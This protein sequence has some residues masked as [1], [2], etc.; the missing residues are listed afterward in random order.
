M[1]LYGNPAIRQGLSPDG[2]HWAFTTTHGS[3]WAPMTWISYLADYQLYGLKPQGYHLTNVLLHSATTIL[4]F[5]V[6]WRMTGQLWPCAFVAAVFA[7]HPLH[8]ESVAWLSERKGLLSGLFFV[9][10]LG[11]YVQYVRRRSLPVRCLAY[12]AMLVFF[13]LGLMSKPM[14]VT[15]PFVLLLLDY[16]PLGRMSTPW[17]GHSCLPGR[18]R[19]LADKNGCPTRDRVASACR[20]D[21]LAAAGGRLLRDRP[22]GKAKPSSRWR[23]SRCRRG[24]AT[25]WS[26]MLITWARRFGPRIWPSSIRIRSTPCRRGNRSS[27]LLVSAGRHG[28][29]AGPLAAQSLSA[30]RLALVRG[31][32]RAGDRAGADW[33]ACDGRPLH[34][35]AADRLCLALT[36]AALDAVRSWP[37]RAW[38]CGALA[39]LAIVAL[40]ACAV[41]ADDLL[42]RQRNSL[43]P[44]DRLHSAEQPGPL[45]SRRRI[46]Q[47]EAVL[48]GDR[49]V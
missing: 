40:M 46:V 48:R 31:N 3:Q 34:V 23:K 13:A 18:S 26:P 24:S 5:L 25:P 7:V 33:L 42:A 32:A 10:T 9:L 44:R 30:G 4:L 35:P 20:E 36:W 43:D 19:P 15:L 49:A 12:L 28:G 6:L 38:A 47:A 29:G 11:A 1:N 27:A 45:E 41:A 14:L 37:H 21:P 2:I 22:V 16:W 8:V 17:S 39:S